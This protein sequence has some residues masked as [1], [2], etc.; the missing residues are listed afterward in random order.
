MSFAIRWL[1]GTR[2]NDVL[3][4]L[5]PLDPKYSC[6]VVKFLF[7]RF[8]VVSPLPVPNNAV[9][10]IL[11]LDCIMLK[12]FLFEMQQLRQPDWLMYYLCTVQTKGQI[13]CLPPTNYSIASRLQIAD[14]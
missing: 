4:L 7:T 6:C 12:L 5:M 10:K 14:F 1:L 13:N 11:L 2:G 9:V 3:I 8:P